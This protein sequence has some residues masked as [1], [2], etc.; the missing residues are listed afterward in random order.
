MRPVESPRSPEAGRQPIDIAWA[1][2]TF[3]V[4]M[5]VSL[6]SKM[7]AIDLAYHLRAGLDVLHGNIPRV[8]TYTFTVAGQPWLDQQW[9]AQGL[10]ALFFKA[11]GWPTLLFV[12]ALV[13]GATFFLVYLAARAA[14]A[15]QLDRHVLGGA[16]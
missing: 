7:G 15:A 5:L 1:S 8:D 6:M 9:G 4:P 12:Q 16:S 10:L 3:L 14:G 11:G 2:L 13:V